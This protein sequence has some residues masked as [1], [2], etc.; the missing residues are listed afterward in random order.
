VKMVDML[1]ICRDALTS[2]LVSNLVLAME[3]NKVGAD[4]GVIF[5]EEALAAVAKGVFRWPRE[6][7][8]QRM[9]FQIA[10][11]AKEMGLPT[12]GG[13]GD[14]R[15]IDPRKL[16]T[17]ANEAGVPMYACPAWL[18][19]LGLQG[20]LPLGIKEIDTEEA[21]RLINEAKKVIGTF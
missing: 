18:A 10:D 17:Q 13:K 20:S 14:G 12:M 15:Q 19:L 1:F 8:E 9:R 3:A 7:A 11:G 5:T 6:L 16:I 2:S 21:M 4:V